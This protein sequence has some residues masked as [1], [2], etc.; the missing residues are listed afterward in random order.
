MQK[1][2]IDI[3]VLQ[4]MLKQQSAQQWEDLLNEAGVP[5]ARVRTVD[6]TLG[7]PQLGS[8]QVIQPA[9]GLPEERADLKVPVAAFSYL[10]NGPA[11]HHHAAHHGQHSREILREIGLDDQRILQLE[12]SGIVLQG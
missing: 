11:L 12:Q 6:E 4:K 10:H 3:A 1:L 5:A 7:H 9:P 8:R 2:P